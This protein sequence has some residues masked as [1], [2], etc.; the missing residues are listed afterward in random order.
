MDTAA[1]KEGLRNP[2]LITM[3][4]AALLS[5]IANYNNFHQLW[6]FNLDLRAGF[7]HKPTP[8]FLELRFYRQLGLTLENDDVFTDVDDSNNLTMLP[9]SFLSFLTIFLYLRFTI[10]YFPSALELTTFKCSR[11]FLMALRGPF[12]EKL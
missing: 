6:I 1:L 5:H 7:F 10:F 2:V 11:L 8:E 3:M 4:L 9:C 12:G